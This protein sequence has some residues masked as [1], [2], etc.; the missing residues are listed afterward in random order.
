MLRY[1][2]SADSPAAISLLFI[3]TMP[4]PVDHLDNLHG[5]ALAIGDRGVLILGASG[6]GKTALAVE[7]LR[8][9]AGSGRNGRL[10][11]DDQVLLAPSNGRLICLAPPTIAGLVEVS[12]SMPQAISHEPAAV[13]DLVV[14]LVEP[15]EA[16]RF[17]EERSVEIAGC[18]VPALTLA[19]R[20]A[21]GA[22]P[23]ITARLSLAPF[24]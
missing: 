21:V 4:Q 20:N 11:A 8:I 18:T 13:I 24:V 2:L 3:K 17:S 16:P 5:T 19:K 23:A 22:L 12:G 9:A 6:S 14:D 7:L 1:R 10:V 15:A